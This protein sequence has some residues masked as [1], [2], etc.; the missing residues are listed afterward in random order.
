V[1]ASCAYTPELVMH[2]SQ[3]FP[4]Q[5]TQPLVDQHIV[6]SG[7]Y[8]NG[9]N[10][11]VT[12]ATP[13]PYGPSEPSLYGPS[14]DITVL[15]SRLV[16]A[17]PQNAMTPA[18]SFATPPMTPSL[19]SLYTE[20]NDWQLYQRQNSDPWGSLQGYVNDDARGQGLHGQDELLQYANMVYPDSYANFGN[21]VGGY[22]QD[23]STYAYNSAPVWSTGQ[24]I[25]RRNNAKFG[26]LKLKAAL[27]W[28]IFK[29]RPNRPIKHAQ[30]QEHED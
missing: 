27:R 21:N 1:G 23:D 22:W 25:P 7:P 4:T 17:S 30:L 11:Q 9:P 6:G 19:M 29:P 3:S 28:G 10:Q 24:E 2:G 26:W 8:M 20:A 12:V 18:A 16:Q 5:A 13:S 14:E 15:P